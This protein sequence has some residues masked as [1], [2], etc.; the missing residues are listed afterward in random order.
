MINFC[1][2]L[3]FLFKIG[4]GDE[5]VFLVISEGEALASGRCL[6]CFW[7]EVGMKKK[8]RLAQ[9]VFQAKILAMK[10]TFFAS[11]LHSAQRFLIRSSARAL[12]PVQMNEP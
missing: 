4:F 12:S 2:F 11:G 7:G 6:F 8:S 9:K 1:V 5:L 3:E 10:P